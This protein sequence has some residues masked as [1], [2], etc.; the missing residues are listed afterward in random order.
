MYHD[1]GKILS[2]NRGVNI[3]VGPRGIGKSYGAKK[4]CVKHA[5]EGKGLFVWVRRFTKETDK[6]GD[7]F[8]D[9]VINDEFPGYSFLY[10]ALTFYATDPSGDKKVIGYAIPLSTSRQFK[11]IP[12]SDVTN[13]VYDE[14]LIGDDQFHYLKDEVII[15]Y[16]LLE[17]II[18]TRENV[19]IFM[20]GNNVTLRNAYFQR[21]KIYPN[22]KKRFWFSPVSPEIILEM[23]TATEEFI[24]AKEES[25]M[26][27]IIGA[28]EYLN[29]NLYNES[30]MDKDT[31]IEKKPKS[32]RHLMDIK[33]E[34]VWYGF[35][36]DEVTGNIYMSKKINSTCRYR[37]AVQRADHEPNIVLID[38]IIKQ[39]PMKQLIKAFRYSY[40]RFENGECHDA[41][42]EMIKLFV[43]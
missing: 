1:L 21:W 8:K 33:W 28:D 20:I 7:F 17:T 13:I 26:G 2:Y 31:F 15:W 43:R 4:R 11:S 38:S 40:I 19:K 5:I 25:L 35:W 42:Y 29:Y 37:F 24:E 27:R 9:L 23:A 12:Y 18:R 3:I 30:L 14:F 32:A 22:T 10:E 36:P 39:G 41:F 16:D 6:L 34:N